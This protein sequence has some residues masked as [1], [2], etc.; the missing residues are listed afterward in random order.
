MGSIDMMDVDSMDATDSMGAKGSSRCCGQ[1]GQA[2]SP[3]V[4]RGGGDLAKSTGRDLAKS[5]GGP[6]AAA[7]EGG[8]GGR[9]GGRGGGGRQAELFEVKDLKARRR[10]L[11]LWAIWVR[12]IYGCY[13]HLQA[14]GG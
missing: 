8:V 12:W 14:R 11:A 6:R 5:P 4:E 2:K 7:V 13:G 10:R 9:G 3:G 1:Y